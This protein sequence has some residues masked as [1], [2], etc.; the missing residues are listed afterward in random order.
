MLTPLV[1]RL[2]WPTPRAWTETVRAQLDCFLIDHAACERKA[3]ATGMA[4]VVRYPDR[5]QI[6]RPLIEFAR[7]EL[8]HF[9]AVYRII[10]SRGLRLGPDE[11]DPYVTQ[12]HSGMRDGRDDKLVDRLLVAAVVEA[13]GCERFRMLGEALSEEG[14]DDPLGEFYLRIAQSEARHHGLFIRLAKTVAD[15]AEVE[16]RLESWLEKEANII[17]HLPLRPALH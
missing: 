15:T 10:E 16:R 12:L 2:K 1:L 6:L 7:E 8:E 9:E 4:F 11:K 5:P 17:S 14:G 3:S 13:R